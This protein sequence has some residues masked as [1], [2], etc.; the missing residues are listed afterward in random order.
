MITRFI[1]WL[2]WRLEYEVITGPR[3]D[4]LRELAEPEVTL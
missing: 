1:N 3:A 2:L 4:A